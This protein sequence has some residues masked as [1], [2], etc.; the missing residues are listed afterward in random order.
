M[1]NIKSRQELLSRAY[2]QAVASVAGFDTYSFGVDSD[3]VDIGIASKASSGTYKSPRL[4]LQLKAPFKRNFVG[5]N[6][7]S[8]SISKKNYDDL[9]ANVYVPRLLVVLMV[10]DDESE[11]LHQSEEQLILRHCAFWAS[12]YGLPDLPIGQDDKSI[13][14][15]RGNV[16]NVESL[17]ALMAMIADGGTP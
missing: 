5:T 16:F 13:R 11:W 6:V 8:Y 1:I 15:S 7:L 2:V 10:A 12:L 3:S 17:R 4:E 9:R 14:F